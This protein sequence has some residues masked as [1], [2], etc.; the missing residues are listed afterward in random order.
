[1]RGFQLLKSGQVDPAWIDRNEHMNIKAYFDLFE[2]GSW[3]LWDRIRRCASVV[4]DDLTMVAGRFYIEH[5]RE[6]SQYR[7]WELWSAC[8]PW[9]A[10][11]LIFV[12]RIRASDGPREI[13]AT[14]EVLVSG[15][16]ME[17]RS[18]RVLP[19][20]LHQ[21]AARMML[22]GYRPRLERLTPSAPSVPAASTLWFV[23]VMVVEGKGNHAGILI[24]GV[25]FADLSL[26]GA[27]IVQLDD[28]RFPKGI[29]ETFPI[30][31][32][33]PAPALAFLQR[34][35]ALCPEIIAQEKANRGWHLT[36]DA[37]DYVLQLRGQRSTDPKNM[38]C[39]EWIAHA[40]DLGGGHVPMD[41][42]TPEQLR[43]W[44]KKHF[45]HVGVQ[46]DIK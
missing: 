26:A 10:T 19:E 15:F 2:E 29:P 23:T 4:D 7:T 25:G 14:C 9:D 5:R 43:Q 27:R 12:H 33:N 34:P 42:L 41:V 38:N 8:V 3:R 11:S 36:P 46:I 1:M 20:T 39:V 32:P 18:A 24:P 40:I 6:L 37:P 16:S 31:I 28:P 13:S 17:A 30:A 22:V 44:A 21:A 35:G 45:R